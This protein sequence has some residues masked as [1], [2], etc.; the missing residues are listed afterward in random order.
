MIHECL[1]ISL[2]VVGNAAEAGSDE[3][4][5]VGFYDSPYNRQFWSSLA[6]AVKCKV[7]DL[8]F[9]KIQLRIQFEFESTD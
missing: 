3:S 2:R 5:L 6:V 4:Q 9:K 8:K 1:L 7:F